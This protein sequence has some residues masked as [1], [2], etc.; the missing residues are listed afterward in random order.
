MAS[1]FR[2]PRVMLGYPDEVVENDSVLDFQTSKVGGIPSWIGTGCQAMSCP[3]CKSSG[4]PLLLA[5][6]YAP[7][8][9]KSLHRTLYIFTCSKNNCQNDPNSWWCLRGQKLHGRPQGCVELSTKASDTTWNDDA[10]DWGSEDDEQPLHNI[11]TVEDVAATCQTLSIGEDQDD[12]DPDDMEGSVSEAAAASAEIEVGAED[13]EEVVTVDAAQSSE[14]KASSTIPQLFSKTNT[15]QVEEHGPEKHFAFDPF[16]IA[17]EEEYLGSA[18]VMTDH[19][20]KLLD[21]Y[22]KNDSLGVLQVKGEGNPK[23]GGDKSEDV[24]E[25]VL[26][27]H[28]DALFH[29]IMSVINLNPGQILRYSRELSHQPL[30][31]RTDQALPKKCRHCSGPVI[32]ELQIL[33]TLIPWLTFKEGENP[34]GIEFGTVLVYTC[35]ASCPT[36]DKGYLTELVVMQ[37]ELLWLP[38]TL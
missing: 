28:G 21:E 11:V 34:P 2:T 26:P 6:I 25:N 7:L 38:K 22:K 15:G 37:P 5:Q 3:K 27:K 23:T 14:A 1:K 13:D 19:E 12:D 20:Q 4:T 9:A 10:D 18:N 17:V 32:C 33:S 16:Y 24:Y 31:V 29:R 35:L 30:L 36:G 8:E